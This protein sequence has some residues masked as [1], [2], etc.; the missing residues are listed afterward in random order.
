MAELTEEL[1]YF[2]Y[3]A[4]DREQYLN[5]YVPDVGKIDL[6]VV[7]DSVLSFA[8]YH[9]KKKARLFKDIW[10]ENRAIWDPYISDVK[11]PVHDA[12]QLGD[13]IQGFIK[14]L[15]E[16]PIARVDPALFN[17]RIL[18]ISCMNDARKKRTRLS[19]TTGFWNLASIT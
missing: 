8:K 14:M 7:S 2:S 9:K 10:N 18:F 17:K 13:L 15:E 1:T 16:G 4:G 3:A 6:W 11:F 5:Q 19:R 12:G